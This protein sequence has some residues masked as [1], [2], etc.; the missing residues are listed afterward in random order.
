[1][2]AANDGLEEYKSMNVIARENID[3]VKQSWGGQEHNMCLI[4][5]QPLL[6][7]YLSYI[8]YNQGYSKAF[9]F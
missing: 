7:K 6:F 1:V 3:G 8:L 9:F 4:F 2:A 5:E